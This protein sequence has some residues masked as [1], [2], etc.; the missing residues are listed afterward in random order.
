M[1]RWLVWC[2]AIMSGTTGAVV[3]TT[4]TP[5][6]AGSLTFFTDP[7]GRVPCLI[8]V[9]GD[10]YPYVTNIRCDVTGDSRPEALPPRPSGCPA[11]W[12]PT[13]TMNAGR[14]PR[15]GACVGDTIAGGRTYDVGEVVSA[16]S[17]SCTML[18]NGVRCLDSPTRR[19]F[20]VTTERLWYL[21]AP[22]R[23]RLSPAG[24]DKLHLGMTKQAGRRTGYLG[25][26]V[27][28]S[29]QL[30]KGQ[31]EAYLSWRNGR[32]VGIL[33]NSYTNLQA[34]KGVGVGTMLRAVTSRYD[35][36]IVATRDLV[37]D[38]RAYVYEVK[39][40]RGSLVFLLD[41]PEGQRPSATTAVDALWVTSAFR[42]RQGYGFSGC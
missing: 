9:P 21:R 4:A 12:S 15:W 10:E 1:R 27:C 32:L 28:G 14:F 17:F 22:A 19:G 13:V 37:E 24:I 41:L 20:T 23:K 40:R 39:G 30:R 6:A 29:P 11:E 38:Q 33:A 25:R 16:G 18:S 5:A 35:G 42:P 8:D 36:R 7:S 26:A 31:G 34:T 3:L 2:L